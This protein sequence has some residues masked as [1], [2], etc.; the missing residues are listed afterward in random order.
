[1]ALYSIQ[2]QDGTACLVRARNGTR[3]LEVIGVDDATVTRITEEGPEGVVGLVGL[4][5]DERPAASE[6]DEANE[7]EVTQLSDKGSRRFKNLSTKEERTE[8]R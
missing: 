3:A 5:T 6:P 1:M 8:P 2:G 7:I 4:D